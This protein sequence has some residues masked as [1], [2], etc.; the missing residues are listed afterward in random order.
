MRQ[1]LRPHQPQADL[2]VSAP[3][4][5]YEQEADRVA[6]EILRLPDTNLQRSAEEIERIGAEDEQ[7]LKTKSH[8][9]GEFE[10]SHHLESRLRN[11][12]GQGQP[13]PET[14][15]AFFEPRFRADFGSVRLH[16]DPRSDELAQEIQAHALTFGHD[17]F[18]GAGE[19]A[20]QT[21]TG[22]RLLAHEL[23]H[24]L[25]QSHGSMAESIQRVEEPGAPVAPAGA[26]PRAPG[27]AAPATGRPSPD[28][29]RRKNVYVLDFGVNRD[30]ANWREVTFHIGEIEAESV[31]QMVREVKSEVGDPADN[32]INRL[33]LD[34]HGSPG[35]MSVGDGTGWIAERN[36][37]TGNFRPSLNELIP[38]FCDGATVVLMGCN[39][40]R[41]AVGT[42]FIQRLS[43][44]WQVNVAAATG[45]VRG[46]GI[47]GVWVWG[48]PGQVL[49]SDARLIT[50][51]IVR[52]LDETTYGDDEEMIFSLLEA[53]NSH[54][55]LAQVTTELTTQGR[56]ANLAV[57]LR[58]ED[59]ARYNR[60]FPPSP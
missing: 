17:I 39:V 8:S 32:C 52:I 30:V 47:E 38:Y 60:L 5:I 1:I 34:G 14:S 31:D 57:D 20:P 56:W 46:Y 55:I 24:V 37:S 26:T 15:R 35:N 48:L 36:I 28:N 53:A 6:G 12:Q 13:L 9:D 16:T 29:R 51:Q 25:Q 27:A 10:L 50:D 33:T 42:R 44:L 54:G 11:L 41:G 22:Q 21:T 4:D 19:Y 49:P 2:A 58:D 3:G 18:F 59:E 23:A 40:G 45:L 43:D 7:L